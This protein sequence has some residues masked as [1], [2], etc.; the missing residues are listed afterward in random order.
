MNGGTAVDTN[1]IAVS[2]NK[3]IENKAGNNFRGRREG[4]IQNTLME[5]LFLKIVFFNICEI[6]KKFRRS[7]DVHNITLCRHYNGIKLHYDVPKTYNNIISN[8][9]KRTLLNE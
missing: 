8:I 7:P 3:Y 6:P 4:G 5:I 1:I 2:D 9:L